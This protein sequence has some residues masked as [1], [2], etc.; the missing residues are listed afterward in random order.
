MLT[1]AAT[2]RIARDILRS[3]LR[4]SS[5]P[6]TEHLPPLSWLYV[7]TQGS[8]QSRCSSTSSPVPPR[9]VRRP[10]DKANDASSR[11][12][13]TNAAV[14]PEPAYDDGVSYYGAERIPPPKANSGIKLNPDLVILDTPD[15]PPVPEPHNGVSI[16][17]NP[18]DIQSNY[19]A[20]IQA[21]QFARAQLVLQQLHNTLD[22]DARELTT[23]HN[24]FLN[25]LFEKAQENK[26]HVRAFFMWYE[27]RMQGKYQVA[28][29]AETIALL[30]KASL[31]LSSEAIGK[32]Y[33]SN[34][35]D[36]ARKSDIPIN[37]VFSRPIFT[38][39][40]VKYITTVRS[41]L[42][43][44]DLVCKLTVW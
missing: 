17:V 35:V 39:E 1:R 6:Y 21:G 24:A 16:L 8:S 11:N 14:M 3:N 27:E 33:L 25:G 42:P 31:L 22:P 23:C 38:P 4:P 7:S 19:F 34:Y 40:E 43:H 32:V 10:L 15:R 37:E 12:F 26:D 13:G 30:L 29:D 18:V 5:A 28:P 41:Q 36:T 9:S 20:C 44:V 2:K